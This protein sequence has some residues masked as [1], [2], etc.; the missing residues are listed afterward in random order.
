M[1]P[2]I[3]LKTRPAEQETGSRRADS[4]SIP[5]TRAAQIMPARL[6]HQGTQDGKFIQAF[7][8][9]RLLALT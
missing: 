5:I 4:S 1:L 8:P 2:V 9:G 3:E 7:N 6:A